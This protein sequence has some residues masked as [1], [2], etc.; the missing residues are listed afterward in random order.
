MELY[1]VI[2]LLSELGHDIQSHGVSHKDLTTLSASDLEDEVGQSKQSL[3]EHDFN[4][5]I[6]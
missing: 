3:L 5:T 2:K 4:S 6:F 1:Y